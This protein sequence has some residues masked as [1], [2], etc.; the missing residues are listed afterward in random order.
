VR[1]GPVF[2]GGGDQAFLRAVWVRD[3]PLPRSEDATRAERNGVLDDFRKHKPGMVSN[4]VSQDGAHTLFE[5]IEPASIG[6][7][8]T[9]TQ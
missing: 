1:E 9:T 2:D 4:R 6:S 8:S 3:L 7:A 5:R